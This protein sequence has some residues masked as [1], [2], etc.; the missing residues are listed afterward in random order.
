MWNEHLDFKH[1]TL[2]L[3]TENTH[4]PKTKWLIQQN[5]TKENEPHQTT[6]TKVGPVLF[7]QHQS[8]KQM[9]KC[10]TRDDLYTIYSNHGVI[11]TLWC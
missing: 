2:P 5:H 10:L 11:L 7:K 1:L 9:K 8:A 6:K 4:I 3:L